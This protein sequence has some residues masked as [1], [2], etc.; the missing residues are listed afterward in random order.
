MN[1]IVLGLVTGDMLQG[2][3]YRF[4]PTSIV[5]KSNLKTGKIEIVFSYSNSSMTYARRSCLE[6]K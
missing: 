6:Y 5:T 2:K 4:Y 3:M 1:N